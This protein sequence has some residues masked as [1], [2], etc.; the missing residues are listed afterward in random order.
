MRKHFP[1]ILVALS[2]SVCSVALAAFLES[3][4]PD[5][6]KPQPP[7]P[8]RPIIPL[9]VENEVVRLITNC[10]VGSPYH[11]RGLTIFPLTL[12]R[13]LDNR[14]YYTFDDAIARGQLVVRE[15][16][17]VPEVLI[18]NRSSRR[19]FAMSGEVLIGGKQNRMIREDVLLP[20]GREVRVPVYCVEKGRWEGAVTEL[21]TQG[22]LTHPAL[23]FQA[24][25]KASQDALW[26][27]IASSNRS[28]SAKSETEDYQQIYANS[29]TRRELSDFRRAFA[30]IWRL[31][32]AGIVVC[33]FGRIVGAEVFG[34]SYLYSRL[35][36]KIL[37]SYVIDRLHYPAMERY[38]RPGTRE[39]ENYLGRVRRARFSYGSTPGDGRS[40]TLSGALNGSA[41]SL[42]GTAVH[43][44]LYE[45]VMR[46]RNK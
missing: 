12:R 21:K 2:I 1:F 44:S 4:F 11:H 23:R 3:D 15:S 32:P 43:V 14:S 20:P 22:T 45:N 34:N 41:L 9:P 28:L 39:I 27:E 7:R 26:A 31:R 10:S 30:P 36:H 38:H 8:P 46:I 5:D 35:Q 6:R 37:D 33:R 17:R 25:K 24:S 18:T 19:V 42:S 40:I 13:P 29:K 16:G